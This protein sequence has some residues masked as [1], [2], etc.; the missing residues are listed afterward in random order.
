[1]ERFYPMT[2]ADAVRMNESLEDIRDA[3][4]GERKRHIFGFHINDNESDPDAKVTYLMDAIGLTPAYMDFAN[5]KWVWGSWEDAFFIPKPCM[6]KADGTVDYYLNPLDYS[7]KMDGTDSDVDDLTYNGNAMMEWG[8]DGKKIWYKI[9]PDDGDDSSCSVFIADYKADEGYHCY[10][11]CNRSGIYTDHFYTPIYNGSLDANGKL[12]SMSGV[13]GSSICKKKTAPQEAAAAALNNPTG[14]D[15]WDTE[16]FADIVLINLLLVLITKSTNSQ[17]K[18]GQGLID[19]G[20]EAVNDGF[21]TG[22]HNDKGLF[23]GTNSGAAG[24]YTNASK[25]FGM[26]NWWGFQW[27]R[28]R[29]LANVNGVAKY[30]MTRKQNDGSTGDDYVIST[31]ASDYNGYITGGNLPSA[32]GTYIDKM[33]FDDKAFIPSSASGTSS[34][35]YCDGL[36]TSNGQVDYAF[37]GG[38]SGVSALCGAWSLFLNFA[39]SDANW[40]VGASPSCKPLL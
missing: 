27:R 14:Y 33:K 34:T 16:V 21:A 12:R 31:T 22:V 19:S 23:Y 37:R 25:V 30:K 17:G 3:V 38:R 11:F 2:H 26:E 35:H 32:S 18:V 36:W 4:I 7:K 13:L 39:A 8:R 10:S 6:L 28:F 9:V 29:G 5:G 24:T 15:I 20:S 40:A 1:M